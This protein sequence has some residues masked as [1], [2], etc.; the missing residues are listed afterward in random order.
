MGK[1]SAAIRAFIESI[2]DEK[3]TGFADPDPSYTIYSNT[4]F[5]LDLQNKTSTKPP[6]YNLQVQVNR[7][8]TIS[9]LKRMK[10]KT[11]NTGTTVAKA[12]VPTD[13]SWN[14]AAVR[15]ALLAGR[16]I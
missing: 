4:D 14:A 16:M 5:R 12:L 9:T 1:A 10:K 7:Q 15:A 8:S 13:G 11:G 2:P 6:N 3:L